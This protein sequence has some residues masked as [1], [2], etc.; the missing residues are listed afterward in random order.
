[1]PNVSIAIQLSSL[2]A[3]CYSLVTDDDSCIAIKTF[4]INYLD[5]SKASEVLNQVDL[6]QLQTFCD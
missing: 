3:Q 1:M 6:H 5:Q 4:G 2:V